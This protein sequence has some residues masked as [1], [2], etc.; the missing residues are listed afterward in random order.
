MHLEYVL[1]ILKICVW[2]FKNMYINTI[3]FCYEF[4]IVRSDVQPVMMVTMEPN[5]LNVHPNTILYNPMRATNV[6][7]STECLLLVISISKESY[8]IYNLTYNCILFSPCNN[9]DTELITGPLPGV[10]AGGG[11]GDTVHPL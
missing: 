10:D 2:A 9:N 6:Q 4:Q 8:Q 3:I 1:G 5:V 7:V 11:L